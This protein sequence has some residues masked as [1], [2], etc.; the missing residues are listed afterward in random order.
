MDKLKYDVHAAH[1]CLLHGCKYGNIDCPVVLGKVDQK[2]TCESCDEDE[3]KSVSQVKLRYLI[4]MKESNKMAGKKIKTVGDAIAKIKEVQAEKDE[5]SAA[6]AELRS[7][8]NWEPGIEQDNRVSIKN[9]YKLYLE[10]KQELI[11]LNNLSVTEPIK[12]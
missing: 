11:D 2:Y 8:K 6:L 12:E 5:Y 9:I 7:K 1:C 4:K 3:I 10:K